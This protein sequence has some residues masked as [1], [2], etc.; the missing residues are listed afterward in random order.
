MCALSHAHFPAFSLSNTREGLAPHISLEECAKGF[1]HIPQSFGASSRK[2]EGRAVGGWLHGNEGKILFPS[3]LLIFSAL[4]FLVLENFK[5]FFKT[6]FVL[7]LGLA[8]GNFLGV[9]F[10][11]M[12]EIVA[13]CSGQTRG[14]SRGFW[15]L[16]RI[17]ALIASF[18]AWIL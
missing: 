18:P 6:F 11:T 9:F 1:L 5:F 4:V 12:L 16:S 7:F 14:Q 17:L 2:G 3:T 8:L 13:F 15:F 10:G